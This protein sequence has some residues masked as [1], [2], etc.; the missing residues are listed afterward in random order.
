MKKT[1][2]FFGFMI[3][4][5]GLLITACK[6]NNDLIGSGVQVIPV[7]AQA[8]NQSLSEILSIDAFTPILPNS[9]CEIRGINNILFLENQFFI[10]DNSTDF[11]HIWSFKEDGTFV[12]KIGEYSE[13]APD[14]YAGING[15]GYTEKPDELLVLD[16]GKM[17]F[18]Q[19]NTSGQLRVNL[20]NAM[21][22]E[23]A[24]KTAN[25]DFVLYNEYG[26]SE[27]SA[28]HHLSIFDKK[29]NLTKRLYPY[30]ERLDGMSY[31]YTGFLN[32][33]DQTIWF[34][35]PFCDTVFSVTSKG[36]KPEY[37]FDFGQSAIPAAMRDHKI[38]GW[39]VDKFSYLNASFFKCGKYI[40][41]DYL[42]QDYAS[43]GLYDTHNNKMI[44]VEDAAQDNLRQILK[45]GSI[46]YKDA[47]SFAF[48]LTAKRLD[49]LIINNKIDLAAIEKNKPA[50][51][52]AIQSVA[53][54]KGAYLML[55]VGLHPTTVL[56]GASSL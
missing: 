24:H 5:L 6:S 47:Q 55:H 21:F 19:Y 7:T 26:S 37:I 34:S 29:G 51:A 30:P 3:T 11:Q 4:S 14:G 17:S 45:V 33:S 43:I 50:L 53:N 44:S 49:H 40:I 38:D 13:S 16:A 56:S 27:F 25:G 52:A 41:F 1:I 2:L 12:G 22:G 18:K 39:D 46:Y 48:V 23:D 9:G 35:P 31:Q 54:T 28:F 10:L 36:V 42:H 32:K 20:P 8:S 15:F